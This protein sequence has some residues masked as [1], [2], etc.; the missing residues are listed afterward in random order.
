MVL[1]MLLSQT[2][3]AKIKFPAV[4]YFE[5][6]RKAETPVTNYLVRDWDE[7]FT[8]NH[9]HSWPRY[10]DFVPGGILD[11]TG[12]HFK[13][14]GLR[15]WRPPPW[16]LIPFE[17]IRAA[18]ILYRRYEL[19]PILEGPEQLTLDDFKERLCKLV[20][21]ERGLHTG[22]HVGYRGMQKLIRAAPDYERCIF[23]IYDKAMYSDERI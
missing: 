1:E 16:F 13:I 14:I 22:G 21:R 17:W 8:R 6:R 4:Q 9:N 12:Q 3:R 15:N 19:D 23:A 11:H 7:T 18:M 10:E 5:P 20:G 2:A